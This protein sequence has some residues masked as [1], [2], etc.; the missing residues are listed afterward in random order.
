M[1]E[2]MKKEKAL[3]K[4]KSVHNFLK[5]HPEW[6]DDKDVVMVAVK[7]SGQQLEY[8]SDELKDDK[9]IGLAAVQQDGS[10][11]IYFERIEKLKKWFLTAIAIVM[12]LMVFL[13]KV[14]NILMKLKRR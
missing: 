3:K 1:K 4:A 8:A 2:L 12:M 5:Y 10:F 11:T 14:G 9:E 7:K 13:M 6:N